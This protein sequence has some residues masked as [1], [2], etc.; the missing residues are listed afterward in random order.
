MQRHRPGAVQGRQHPSEVRAVLG[1]RA[2]GVVPQQHRGRTESSQP[3]AMA[4]PPAVAVPP[5]LLGLAQPVYEH[6]HVPGG[7]RLHPPQR[8]GTRRYLPSPLVHCERHR[9][10]TTLGVHPVAE[11]P[12]DRADRHR[13]P[14]RR[15]HRRTVAWE[16]QRTGDQSDHLG[17]APRAHPDRSVA[18][19]GNSVVHHPHRRGD[20]AQHTE[21]PIRDHPVD[22]LRRAARDVHQVRTQRSARPDLLA[23]RRRHD[24]GA[25]R[26]WPVLVSV[27]MAREELAFL[28][29]TSVRM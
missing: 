11:Q 22:A 23:P 24:G 3:F 12:V 21:Y 10:V 5:G 25:H 26:Y 16:R 13:S 9:Q 8:R 6:H 17:A 4:A 1:D 20:P 19:S 27:S 15:G 29:V 28:P 18:A 7:F 2:P 14:C